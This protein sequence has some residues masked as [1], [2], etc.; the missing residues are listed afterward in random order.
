MEPEVKALPGVSF[1]V[2]TLVS[3]I[4]QSQADMLCY[5]ERA[6]PAYSG[7]RYQSDLGPIMFVLLLMGI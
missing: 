4:K 7:L 3:P 6:N 5:L 1:Y 2:N